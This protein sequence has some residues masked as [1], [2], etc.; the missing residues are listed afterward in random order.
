[1]KRS[2]FQALVYQIIRLSPCLAFLL[3]GSFPTFTTQDRLTALV[4]G[5]LILIVILITWGMAESTVMLWY[6][7][8]VQ[9]LPENRGYVFVTILLAAGV[10]VLLQLFRA[11]VEQPTF[12]LALG[13]LS[14]RGMSRSGW[15]QNRRALAFGTSFAGAALLGAVSFSLMLD[16]IPWQG[17]LLACAFGSMVAAVECAWFAGDTLVDSVAKWQTPLFRC[18]LFLGPIVV[19]TLAFLSQLPLCFAAV[20]LVLPAA[21]KVAKVVTERGYVAAVDFKAAAGVYLLFVGIILACRG[22]EHGWFL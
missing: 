22:Y 9:K 15:E 16:R 19:G 10:L 12:L 8:K 6:K 21:A 11:R 7:A 17:G 18:A 14:L 2:T 4:S 1:M 3:F 13:S 20:Y 5:L